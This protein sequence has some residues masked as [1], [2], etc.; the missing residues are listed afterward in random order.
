MA[1]LYISDI[2]RKGVYRFGRQ[3]PP[4]IIQSKAFPCRREVYQE[5]Y[6]YVPETHLETEEIII[7]NNFMKNFEYELR[8][9]Y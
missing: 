1:G 7:L 4:T 2:S 3:V 5:K 9:Y 6:K 8:E